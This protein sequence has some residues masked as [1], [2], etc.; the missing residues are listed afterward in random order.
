MLVERGDAVVVEARGARAED[1]HVLPGAPNASRLRTSWRATSRRASSAPRRSNLLIATTS[2]KSSMSIFS[3]C[4]AA[5]N[6]G[7]ITYSETSTSV[8]DRRVALADAGGLHDDEVEAGRAAGGDDVGQV[9]RHLGARPPRRQGPEERAP[10]GQAFI[11]IRSPSSAPP[12]RRRVGSTARTAIAQLVLL[13][14]A[15]PAHQLVGERGLA[16]AA[17]TGDAEDRCAPR[18][19]GRA[20]GRRAGRGA[21]TGLDHRDRPGQRRVVTREHRLRRR[22]AAAARSTSHA[23]DHRVDHPGEAEPLAVLRREDR[24]PRSASSARSRRRR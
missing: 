2:A 14:Q 1:R 22:G 6:S 15:Q 7:V 17:G 18:G 12:P 4:D 8:D 21:A 24:D 16:R 13:V 11:R 23:G 5:P 10:G 19:R 20:Q 3:S 9:V